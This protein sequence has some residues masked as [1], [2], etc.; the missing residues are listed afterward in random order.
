MQ[1]SSVAIIGK[2]SRYFSSGV[3]V[4]PLVSN[5]HLLSCTRKPLLAHAQPLPLNF[6]VLFSRIGHKLGYHMADLFR[7][8]CEISTV[9][10]PHSIPIRTL[11]N[12]SLPNVI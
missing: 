11:Q 5:I 9:H 2:P 1:I 4:L 7:R 3:V 12:L 10:S 8:P 6:S